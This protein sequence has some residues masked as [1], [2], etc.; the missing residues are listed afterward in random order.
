M[1]ILIS[2]NVNLDL[3]CKNPIK[4]LEISNTG[5][6]AILQNNAPVFYA[7]TPSFFEKIFDIKYNLS[8]KNTKKQNIDKKFAMHP[9]WTPDK[10]FI[11]QA[12]LWGILLTEEILESEL[13][14]FI[15]Y[16]QAEGCFFYHIQWQQ[17]LARS[18]EKSR[19][20]NNYTLQKKRDITY[21]PKPDQ[22]I[23]NGF[24]GK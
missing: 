16:W 11:R 19:S 23:P 5:A 21:I 13:A 12:A 2:D 10:D 7:I 20:L 6:V 4:M 15:S 9:Q 3:F 8:Y 1:K 14:C 24:R 22:T 18:L 17:K